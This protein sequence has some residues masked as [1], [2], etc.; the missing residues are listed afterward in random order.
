MNEILPK[1]TK[2]LYSKIC[3]SLRIF[4]SIFW[5][6]Y[7]WNWTSVHYS[8]Q[9]TSTTKVSLLHINFLRLR[10][11]TGLEVI[12]F[13]HDDWFRNNQNRTWGWS[14]ECPQLFKCTLVGVREWC[15]FSLGGTILPSNYKLPISDIDIYTLSLFDSLSPLHIKVE[16][17]N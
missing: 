12:S 9:K 15:G 6:D 5:V 16:P 3:N 11:D 7:S 2:T 13:R 14:K 8:V 4:S 10:E 1:S 17:R